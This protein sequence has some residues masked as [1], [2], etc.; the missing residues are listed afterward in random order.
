MIIKFIPVTVE[1]IWGGN[2][3]QSLYGY[4]TSD[5]CGECW[6]ISAHKSNSSV[7]ENTIYKGKTLR[8]LYNEQRKLFGNY[9]SDE[10]PILVKII[11]AK[12]NLS[13][14]VHP[15]DDYASK[16]GSLGKEEC[17]YILDAEP[18]TNIIIGH[19]ATS[20]QEL[21]QAIK[22]NTLDEFYNK[23]KIKKGDFFYINAGT[24]H[25]ICGGTTILEVQQSSNI[26]YR[27]YDYGRLVNGI[28]RD[29][30]IK[31][32]LDVLTIPDETITRKHNNRYFNYDII[33]NNKKVKQLSHTHGDYIFIIDGE[34]MFDD[35]P[36]KKGDFLMI[37]SDTSYV[38]NGHLYY[39]KTTF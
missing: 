34:G 22:K 27:L 35:L 24:M 18:D 6:G 14:Q 2:K 32:S 11:D 31:E 30:H 9:K 38:V 15:N 3:F 21:E 4:N 10:F 16:F 13:I 12:T 26:T 5:T 39:Q 29:L 17:W 1:K 25:A 8:D 23:T 28:P 20:K 19:T 37:P 33:T 7:I 36:V